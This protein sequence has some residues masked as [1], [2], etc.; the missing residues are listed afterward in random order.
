M[1]LK[2]AAA[3][4][5]LGAHGIDLLCR[6]RRAAE[7]VEDVH[8]DATYQ[9]A[10]LPGHALESDDPAEIQIRVIVSGDTGGKVSAYLDW[11]MTAR[12]MVDQIAGAAA[13]ALL[14]ESARQALA[15]LDSGSYEFE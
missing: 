10:F 2:L 4:P 1:F 13:L 11:S 14:G 9:L 3:K 12:Q 5:T 15:E 8:A 7:R 6:A